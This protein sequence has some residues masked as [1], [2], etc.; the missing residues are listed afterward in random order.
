MP[1][2]SHRRVRA[3]CAG[4]LAMV[5]PTLALASDA[6]LDLTAHWAG[7][8]AIAIFVGAYLLVIA[9]EFTQLRKSQPVMLA[10]GAIW[11]LLA[12][13][14]AQ[15]GQAD[16]AHHAVREYLLEFAGLLLFLLA[17]MTYVN[18]MSE[19]NLF[20]AL[21][22]RLLRRRCPRSANGRVR[23]ARAPAPP[24]RVR[25]PGSPIPTQT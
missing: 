25:Q 18:A 14:S 16:L 19:R 22:V 23:R 15:Q 7:Y 5:V 1:I 4:A 24:V 20:E 8:A 9:E 17:A 2:V 11:A 3:A 21:R 12:M 13:V 10:A 6:G